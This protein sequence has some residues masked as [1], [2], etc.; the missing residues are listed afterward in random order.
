MIVVDNFLDEVTWNQF[1]DPAMWAEENSGDLA[2][3]PVDA[4]VHNVMQ[5]VAKRLWNFFDP[6]HVNNTGAIG[7]EYWYNILWRENGLKWHYDKDEKHWRDTGEIKIPIY[8]AVLYP[9]HEVDGGYL[10][11]ENGRQEVERIAPVPNRAIFFSAGEDRHR[12]SPIRDGLRKTFACNLW[13][14]V[15]SEFS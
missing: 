13:K 5:V 7:Y 4:P 10:E 15:P 1:N 3:L 8:G 12:V 11:I 9:S 14:E 2:W 6:H